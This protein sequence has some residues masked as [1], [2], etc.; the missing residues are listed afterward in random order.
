MNKTYRDLIYRFQ[1]Q[2]IEESQSTG[3][4]LIGKA[5]H[6]APEAWLNTL[7][8]PLSKNDVQALEKELGM[9]IS[10][11]YKKIPV[12]CK[13]WV[14]HIGWNLLFRRVKKKL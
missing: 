8:P 3:A 9:E 11:D 14:R 13:Q 2:G 10:I 6:I 7:Y 1:N 12:R 4:I 5:P